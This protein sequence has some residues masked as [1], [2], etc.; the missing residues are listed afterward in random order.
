[1][2]WMMKNFCLKQ[3]ELITS[4]FLNICLGIIF[5]EWSYIMNCKIYWID[6]LIHVYFWKIRKNHDQVIWHKNANVAFVSFHFKVKA[7]KFKKVRAKKFVKSNKSK[8]FFPEIA[9]LAVLN[10]FPILKL[11]FGHFWNRKIW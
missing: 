10:F 11:I 3:W 2:Q 4:R 1:M 9:F 8:N 7:R 6:I 5:Y